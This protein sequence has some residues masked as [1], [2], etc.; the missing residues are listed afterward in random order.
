MKFLQELA[1]EYQ[2]YT[3]RIKSG[4]YSVYRT[5]FLCFVVLYTMKLL[6]V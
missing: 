1:L 6:N 4:N 3:S 2:D 5:V